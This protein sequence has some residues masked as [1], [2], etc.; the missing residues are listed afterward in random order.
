MADSLHRRNFIKNV[1]LAGASIAISDVVSAKSNE[2][3]EIKNEWFR[4]SFDKHRGTFSVYRNNGIVLLTG[5]AVCVN[6]GDD[7]LSAAS[8]RYKHSAVSTTFND[9]SGSGKRLSVFSKDKNKTAD[10]EIRAS[11]YDQSTTIMFEAI[12]KNVSGHD[13][14]IRSIEPLRVIGQEGGILSM[15]GVSKCITNGE[16]YF[17]AGTIHE[18]G[19]NE[20]AVTSGNLKGVKLANS[21]ISAQSETIHSWWNAGLFSGYGKEGI[22]IGYP[23][24]NVGLGN[25]L[26]ARTSANQVSFIAESVYAPQLVLQPGKTISSN[27]VMIN[28]AANPY[29][30][31]EDYADITGK[32]NKAGTHSI[33]NGWCSWFYTLSKVSEEEVLTNTAFAAKHLKPFGLE[34]I[35]I[36]EGFQKWH[37]EWEGNERFP[38]GM[39][40]LADKI[41]GYGFKPGLW[42]SPYVISEPAEVFQKH[43]E[44]LL[45]NADG[46]LKRIGNWEEGTVPPADENP[47]RYGLDI[48]HPEAAKWLHD[49][50][51][52]IV[53]DWG[54]AMIKIDFVAWSILAAE[55]Y[56]DPAVSAAQVYRKGMEIMR[57][58]AGDKCHILECG[59]GSIT[60]GLIDSMRIELDVNYGFAGTAWDTYFLHPASSTSAAA[61]RFYF[62]KRT[63]VNDADHICM[64]LLNHQQSEAAATI[65][66]L[67]GGNMMSGDRLT[68]LDPYKLEILKKITPSFGEAAIPVDLF[69]DAMQSVFALKIKK[70]FAEWSVVAFFNASLTEAVEKK[71]PMERLWLD[72]NKTY[73]V[74]DFW[75]QQFVGEIT[76]EIIVT[77]QP[78]SV[79]LLALHE[80]TGKPQFI[81]TD[82]HVLQGAIEM[83]NVFWNEDTKTISGTSMAPL[84]TA[85]NVFVYVPE[86]HPWTWSGSGLFRDHEA[87]S[88][89]LFDKHI[90]RVHV[91]FEKAEKINW[92]IKPADF[93][94]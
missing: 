1:S 36:D 62:H 26:I 45:K 25:L 87:Y 3:D 77:V 80:K 92:E 17:D 94:K 63:W 58:A 24:N 71:F 50:I 83:E 76:N 90:I 52:T 34:Y 91:N 30:A 81:S 31:L 39:K 88:L 11:L 20:D 6:A 38:H 42:I 13:L 56:Y 67:S 68:Q 44:W 41:K 14:I 60:T 93:I 49:L 19:T 22:V 55:H 53:N 73:L 32:I 7:K 21:S 66:A 79:T 28:T 72:P 64:D 78:G 70:S 65:I 57:N 8:G 69:D 33:V 4:V 5:G 84:N 74:F 35:Q 47:K 18:F 23:E 86:E 15:P 82:R 43:P 59:P 2:A 48:T 9:R 46:S 85:H 37:G 61:K 89:K 29:K 10:I 16:M 12:C 27:I 54:Y 51:N 40:W 75:R